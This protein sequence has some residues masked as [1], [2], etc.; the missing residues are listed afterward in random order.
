VAILKTWLGKSRREE[1]ARELGLSG[2][3]FWQL[4]QQA[5]SGLVVGCLRQP[6]FRGRPP[7]YV[8]EEGVGAL[9]KKIATLEREVE[10]SRRLI[11][12]LRELPG[13]REAAARAGAERPGD[14]KRAGTRKQAAA[15][16][17]RAPGVDRGADDGRS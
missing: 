9:R 14:G 3:R 6:R 5:V 11:E 15:A 1:A 13:H 10:S 17:P 8:S 4:S 16:E 2:V 12:V 7:A